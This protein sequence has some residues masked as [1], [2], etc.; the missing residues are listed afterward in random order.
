M[1]PENE[2]VHHDRLPRAQELRDDLW[3]QFLIFMVLPLLC[4][5]S[6]LGPLGW[7]DQRSPDMG[8]MDTWTVIPMGWQLLK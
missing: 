1:A 8:G 6:L 4:L 3:V 5:L 7:L 2:L